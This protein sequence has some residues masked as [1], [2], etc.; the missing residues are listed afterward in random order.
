MSVQGRSH[1]GARETIHP[2]P[3]PLPTPPPLFQFPNQARSNS[4][5]FKHQGYSFLRVFR[6]YTDQKF[7]DFYLYTTIFGQYR[8]ASHFFL[9]CRGNRSLHVWP[10]EKALYLTLDLLKSLLLWTIQKKTIMNKSLNVRLKAESWTYWRSPLKQKKHPYKW[11]TIEYNSMNIGTSENI[12]WRNSSIQ[13]WSTSKN[14]KK[15]YVIK[16]GPT[17][18]LL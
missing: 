6:N 14:W 4:F 17:E 11:F 3:S 2:T 9:L 8:A 5:S 12:L 10:S 15:D 16:T 7:H 18:K 13:M 1:W